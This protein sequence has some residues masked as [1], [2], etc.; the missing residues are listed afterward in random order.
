MIDLQMLRSL[1]VEEIN[2]AEKQVI[3]SVYLSL[4][5]AKEDDI[6]TLFV[7]ETERRLQEATDSGRVA[8]A[9]RN[10]LE[11]GYGTIDCSPPN[12]LHHI[13]DG[14][15][16]RL[17]KQQPTEEARTGGDFGLLVI[18]PQFQVQWG[19]QLSLQRGGLKR[20]LLVQA[21]RRYCDGR[22]NQLTERQLRLLPDRLAYTA[23]LRYEFL[24]RNRRNL[25]SF[26]W[27]SLSVI[28]SISDVTRWLTS[29]DFPKS[30]S[31]SEI[32]EGLSRG[33]Y[34]TNDEGIIEE[35]IC[36]DAGSYVVIEVDWRDGEH[37]EGAILA[38][39]Q[40]VTRETEVHVKVRA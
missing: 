2:G 6:T 32:I 37:P 31:T 29:G 24:D 23:L 28:S 18:E 40:E 14:L 35:E 20:G 4:E 10:D 8:E 1:L 3:R 21:K 34:G 25:G 33:Q 5:N 7:V 27:H 15:I 39:N 19:A 16:A 38:T 22:W 17:R 26:E 30:V 13:T 9:V 12:N 11:N 36:P